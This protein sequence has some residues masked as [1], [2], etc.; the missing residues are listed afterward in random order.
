MSDEQREIERLKRL[1]AQQINARDPAEKD[2]RLYR[3]ASKRPRATFTLKN[4][5]ESL[6]ARFTWMLWGLG[7]G[8]IWGLI[9]GILID[10]TFK[11]SWAAFM[12]LGWVVFCGG[13]GF[14]FGSLKDSGNEGWR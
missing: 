8:L 6:G 7:I 4:T 13:L 10:L 1:R 12:T 3:T 9:V 2:R 11:S 14:Y 5:I